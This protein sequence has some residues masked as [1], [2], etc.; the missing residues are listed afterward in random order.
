[1]ADFIRTK[2]NSFHIIEIYKFGTLQSLRIFKINVD[3]ATFYA[4]F[5]NFDQFFWYYT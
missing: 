4:F 5:G 1:M 3:F 2:N